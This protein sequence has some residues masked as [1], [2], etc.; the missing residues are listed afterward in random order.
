MTKSLAKEL[1]SRG[2]TVNAIAPGFIETDMTAAMPEAAKTAVSYTHLVTLGGLRRA[3]LE[4]D[5]EHGSVMA[6]Q[7]AGMLHEIKPVKQIFE[8]L[9][10]QSHTVLEAVGKEW[11]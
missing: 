9:Y 1:A 11:L 10:A 7:V 4:G 8:E 2:V 6:G 5:V 3:V